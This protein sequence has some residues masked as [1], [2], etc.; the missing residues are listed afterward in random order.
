MVFVNKADRALSV[1]MASSRAS[2]PV[3]SSVL[4]FVTFL[5]LLLLL[6]G[7]QGTL[8][9]QSEESLESLA[10]HLDQMSDSLMSTIENDLDSQLRPIRDH[11]SKLPKQLKPDL[12]NGLRFFGRNGEWTSAAAH[13]EQL[14]GV[15][16]TPRN[17]EENELFR[18]YAARNPS[19]NVWLGISDRMQE[20]RWMMANGQPL[21]DTAELRGLWRPGEPNNLGI[22]AENDPPAHCVLLGM[23]DGLWWDMPCQGGRWILADGYF[24]RLP[25]KLP[26]DLTYHI[27]HNERVNAT[28]FCWYRGGVLAT[29]RNRLENAL[30]R[31]Y[32][33]GFPVRNISPGISDE[34]Q[35]VRWIMENGVPLPDTA[36]LRGLLHPGELNNLGPVH[37]NDT[38]AHCA[39]PLDDRLVDLPWDMQCQGGR[40]VMSDGYFC[41]HP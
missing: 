22:V 16:A 13:C 15:L 36:E 29:P 30:F 35:E 37:G 39:L 17:R 41:R 10:Y 4:P 8:G 28:E 31:S 33:M 21:P 20:G 26:D 7:S 27:R 25:P 32:A 6:G 2:G 34:R 40:W 19:R 3:G 24:C 23:D 14:G 38:S 18:S 12:P 1:T 5:S 11:I 9:L